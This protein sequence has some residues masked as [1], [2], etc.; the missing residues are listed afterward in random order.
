MALFLHR[1]IS[2]VISGE[3]HDLAVAVCPQLVEKSTWKLAFWSTFCRAI[4]GQ[5]N[6]YNSANTDGSQV[7]FRELSSSSHFIQNLSLSAISE[8]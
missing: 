4:F 8:I 7:P 6:A 1:L 5:R 3:L 2:T